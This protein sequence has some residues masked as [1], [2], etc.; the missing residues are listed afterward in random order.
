MI[1]LREIMFHKLYKSIE[2]IEAQ[3]KWSHEFVIHYFN[4][5]L[6]RDPSSSELNF[7]NSKLNR[8]IPK[9]Q[10][11]KEISELPGSEIQFN[12]LEGATFKLRFQTLIRKFP[13]LGY[14]LVLLGFRIDHETVHARMN[15]SILN[16]LAGNNFNEPLESTHVPVLDTKPITRVAVS[17]DFSLNQKIVYSIFDVVLTDD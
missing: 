7:F 1:E 4:K 13:L 14:F 11:I 15:K 16:R 10:I 17:N 5:L 8:G 3:H 12:E 2:F 9:I 6:S